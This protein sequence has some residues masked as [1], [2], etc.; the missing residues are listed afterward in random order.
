M[1]GYSLKGKTSCWAL[2]PHHKKKNTFGGS[3][4]CGHNL[5]NIWVC[6][7][8]PVTGFPGELL[9]GSQ[10]QERISNGHRSQC[11]RLYH[12]LVGPV[13]A[14]FMEA[15]PRL[16]R[17]TVRAPTFWNKAKTMLASDYPSMFWEIPLSLLLGPSGDWALITKEPCDLLSV[18]KVMHNRAPSL[19][20]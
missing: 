15:V 20:R 1:S 3:W 19:N 12:S 8:D 7:A 18:S 16:D 11:K 2:Y 6:C 4:V 5:Y 14:H 10:C 13:V 17:I 9:G